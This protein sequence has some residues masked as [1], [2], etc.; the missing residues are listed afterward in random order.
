V[1][2]TRGERLPLPQ[3]RPAGEMPD[4]YYDAYCASSRMQLSGRGVA[5]QWY[6]L[7]V[8]AEIAGSWGRY[9]FRPEVGWRWMN[10]DMTPEAVVALAGEVT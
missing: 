9:G 6:A 2:V 4:S 5:A 7:G 10:E 8:P 1:T 3:V